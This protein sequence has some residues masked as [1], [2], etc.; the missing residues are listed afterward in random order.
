[1]IYTTA[2]DSILYTKAN[3]WPYAFWSLSQPNESVQPM[4]DWLVQLKKDG[5]I[6]GRVAATN[7]G[8]ELGVEMANAFAKLAP[9]AGLDLV[10]NKSYPP[11]VTDLQP[12][13]RE[14][15]ATNP[16]AFFSFSYP[17]DT[18]MVTGQAQQLGFS[19][20]VFY[21]CIGGVFPGYRDQFGADKVEGIFAYGGQ[22]PSAPGYEDYAKAM[23][24]MYNQEP[25]A[26]AVQVYAC[27]QIVQQAIEKVGEIDRKKIRDEM[28]KGG[29]D[30][31]WGDITWKDQLNASPW[32]VGQ[33]QGGKMVGV[34]P[35]N[36]QNAKPPLFPKP[37]WA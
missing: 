15:M 25:E 4:I 37:K 32:A 18:F 2:G 5:K 30:T 34:F 22:D 19:P 29:K 13:L 3:D 16:D 31:L 26:G 36:K 6:K 14:V 1:M 23:K 21:V 33:W 17:P 8:I 9:K 11:D 28:A 27:L 24:A 12:L 10:F 20:D 35:A 7:I